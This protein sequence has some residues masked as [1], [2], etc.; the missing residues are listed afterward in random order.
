MCGDKRESW[1][2]V[3]KEWPKLAQREC[4]R[5][6]DNIERMNAFGIMHW[7]E[8]INV[9]EQIPEGVIENDKSQIFWHIQC[10]PEILNR[11]SDIVAVDKKN[12]NENKNKKQTNNACP[13][14]ANMTQL[15]ITK[16]E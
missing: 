5:R 2:H 8:G 16:L 4:K 11:K 1:K 13:H 14:V 10:D 12:K 15:M 6:N 7:S 9:Y 3:V